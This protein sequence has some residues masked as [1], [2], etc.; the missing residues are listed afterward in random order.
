MSKDY[1]PRLTGLIQ[2]ESTSNR[3]V[4]EQLESALL[5]AGPLILGML[6]FS[7][8]AVELF[9]SQAFAQAVEILRWQ[10]LGVLVRVVAWPFGYALL[11]KELKGKFFFSELLW[12]FLYISMVWLGLSRLGLRITGIAYF[13]S[14][15]IVVFVYYAIVHRDQSFSFS[16]ENRGLIAAFGSA[17][18]FVFLLSR[19]ST[20]WTYLVGG[21]LTGGA[22]VYCG[23]SLVRK[24]GGLEFIKRHIP[25]VISIRVARLL[26]RCKKLVVG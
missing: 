7:P 4:N 14:Y 2:D 21:T 1:Y 22:A 10:L 12:N 5:L 15:L 20:L 11:A 19:I 3:L 16:L 6:A 23:Y 8:L 18:F 13:I 17:M 25:G 26:E 9:Y 24:V